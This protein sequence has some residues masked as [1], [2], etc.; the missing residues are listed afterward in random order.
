MYAAVV[1]VDLPELT[2]SDERARAARGLATQ[3][4]TLLGFLAFV[5]LEATAT[6][7]AVV[8]IF[9]DRLSLDAA[10]PHVTEWHARH[11]GGAGAG[12]HWLGT[13]EIIAQ[14]GL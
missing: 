10:Q 3:L 5:A 13:G 8:A 6:Q 14:K 9:E 4:S 2:P 1:R 11:F 7:I 12:I